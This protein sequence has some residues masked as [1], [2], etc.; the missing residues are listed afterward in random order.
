[1]IPQ[2][3]KRYASPAKLNLDLRITGRRNDGYHNLESIFIFIDL[4]DEIGI[5]LR[6]DGCIVLHTAISGVAEEQNLLMR[7]AQALQPFKQKHHGADIWVEKHIPMGGG[8]GGGSSNAATVLLVLNQ[9]WH[10]QLSTTQ[11]IQI[12]GQLGADVPFFLF[13]RNAFARGIGEQLQAFNVPPQHYI[14]VHPHVHVSTQLIFQHPNLKRDSKPCT[15][16]DFEKL[17]PFRNDM[18]DIVLQN[19]PEVAY[20]YNTLQKHGNPLMTGSGSCLF[21]AQPNVESAQSIIAKL[22]EIGTIYCVAG[23]EYNPVLKQL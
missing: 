15:Q 14:V 4:C 2:E 17:Q 6:Q 8:L 1:M 20:A 22:P 11:L 18:Q 3:I 7:A 13:G 19:Y 16:I 9:L 21:L 5:R 12:G 23:L 10:C